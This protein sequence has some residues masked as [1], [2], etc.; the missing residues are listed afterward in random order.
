MIWDLRHKFLAAAAAA[1][2]A[3]AGVAF[4]AWLGAHDAWIRA[5]ATVAQ[6]AQTIDQARQQTQQIAAGIQAR[7]QAEAKQ[8]ATMQAEVDR[9]KTAQQIAQWLPQQVPTP[10]PVKIELPAASP[11]NPAPPATA[12]IPQT[13]L[14]ALRDYVESCKACSVKLAAAQQD[15]AAR[16]SELQLAGEQ[17][18]AAEKQRDAA[19]R[20]ARGGGFWHRVGAAFKW[21]AIGAGAGAALLCGSGHCK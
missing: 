3:G 13:D 19:L 16:E 21:L 12:T 14:P 5:Q 1:G 7:D 8:L 18:S 9:L 4:S 15:L 10:Q 20:A 11:G 2:I 17:L 6:Q